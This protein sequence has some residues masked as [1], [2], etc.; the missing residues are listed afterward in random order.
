MDAIVA[1]GCSN[2][3]S[4]NARVERAV[5]LLR[6]GLAERLVVSGGRSTYMCERAR[7]LG[8]EECLHEARST[9]TGE[10]ALYS[11]E[12]AESHAWTRLAIVT[13]AFH[14]RRTRLLFERHGAGWEMTFHESPDGM[15]GDDLER[16]C[17]K[18]RAML[19]GMGQIDQP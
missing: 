10:N 3:G 12:L 9:N 11:L 18:E 6:S 1:L 14:M 15:D 16:Y 19:W 17:L 5:E 7:A 2:H 13:S 4:G 8:V